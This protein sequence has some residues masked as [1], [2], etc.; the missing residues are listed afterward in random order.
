VERLARRK[1]REQ[2]LKGISGT[3]H[4]FALESS[5]AQKDQR[6][7]PSVWGANLQCQLA[8]AVR[9]AAGSAGIAGIE[10]PRV[11][12]QLDVLPEGLRG[13]AGTIRSDGEVEA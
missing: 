1:K 6:L 4:V 5:A 10:L 11:E 12:T 3:A 2:E 9:V 8:G 13:T 7:A